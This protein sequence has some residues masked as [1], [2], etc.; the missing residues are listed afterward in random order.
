[1]TN[2]HS[3]LIFRAGA[4]LGAGLTGWFA[5]D[6]F[7]SAA[8]GSGGPGSLEFILF[9]GFPLAIVSVFLWWV[10]L[11]GASSETRRVARAGCYGALLLGGG[12]FAL[13]LS[14]PLVLPWDALRGAVTA[15]QFA[16]LAGM[17]GLLA[18]LVVA[19]MRKRRL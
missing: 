9:W 16:P 13:L 18:G 10:A 1:V 12:A 4:G 6:S 7:R 19:R 17:L 14:S 3:L 5:V 11:R 2:G 15:V 8:L